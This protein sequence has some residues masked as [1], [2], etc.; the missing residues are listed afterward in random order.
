[1]DTNKG[2]A[3]QGA[4]SANDAK[5][6]I[7]NASFTSIFLANM[8]TYVGLYM[9]NTLVPK[10]VDFL[11][12]SEFVVGAVTSSYAL[13]ALCFK[14]ISAPAID[15]FNK[16]NLLIAV[17]TALTS[18]SLSFAAANSIPVVVAARLLQ[19][20]AQAFTAVCA[21]TIA[22]ESLPFERLGEG[23]ALFSLGQAICQAI[24]PSLALMLI[25]RFSYRIAFCVGAAMI[26]LA[27]TAALTLHIEYVRTKPFHISLREVFAKEALIPA[28]LVFFLNIAHSTI[29]AFLVLYSGRKGISAVG[30]YFTVYAFAMLV[31]RPLV[32]KLSDRFGFVRTVLPAMAFF[33][34]T[35]IL[36]SKAT[37]VY[38]LWLA[39][40]TTAFSYGASLPA[41]QAFCMKTVPSARRGAAG[42][43][44]YIGLDL[45][46]LLGG[47]ISGAAAEAFGFEAMWR[48]M[49]LPIAIAVLIV[50]LCRD[51]IRRIEDR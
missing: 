42:C 38:Y 26:G 10:Y 3:G 49:I 33:T 24:S 31:S 29:I 11:G 41:L 51:R 23:I 32:G 17:L 15:T 6:A 14:L 37:N 34:V 22:S 20:A 2:P 16:K 36:I 44:I 1:M 48:L 35:F 40:A 9:M 25:G 12:G 21:M 45:S 13:A 50:I 27:I 8:F 46:V 30:T 39:G 4:H 43:T 28:V 7:W 19:G 47:F 18:A 5:A